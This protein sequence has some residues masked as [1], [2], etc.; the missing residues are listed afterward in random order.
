MR[1]CC[2]SPPAWPPKRLHL[3]LVGA[4]LAARRGCRTRLVVVAAPQIPPG[5]SGI[6]HLRAM[7]EAS[8]KS[9][10]EERVTF[11]SPKGHTIVAKLRDPGTKVMRAGHHKKQYPCAL[12]ALSGSAHAMGLPSRGL[13]LHLQLG[14]HAWRQAARVMCGEDGRLRLTL[15]SACAAHPPLQDAV[16]LCHGLGDHKDGFCLPAMAEALAKSGFASLRPDFPGNGESE[17][18]FRY[19]NMR[20]EARARSYGSLACCCSSHPPHWQRKACG[21]RC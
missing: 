11:S 17:G 16:I 18:T 7:A 14:M 3:S 13:L 6:R 15:I 12:P 20:D 9:T 4:C 5:S 1:C 10:E 2:V 19:A 8:A 21:S